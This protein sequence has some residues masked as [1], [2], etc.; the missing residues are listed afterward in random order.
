MPAYS[1]LSLLDLLHFS[2]NN[3]MFLAVLL[4]PFDTGMIW[5]NSNF[6]L[7][8]DLA[9]CRLSL[10]HTSSLTR[11]GILSFLY[12]DSPPCFLVDV[13][14]CCSVSQVSKPN[15]IPCVKSMYH[16][17]NAEKSQPAIFLILPL[18]HN[19]DCW[20]K[21]KRPIYIHGYFIY[22][23][24]GENEE[25]M[26]YISKFEK[27]I[28]V[29]SIT[30]QKLRIEQFPPLKEIV[31]NTPGYHIS[32]KCILYSDTYSKKDLKKIRRKIKYFFY[33]PFSFWAMLKKCY[34]VRFLL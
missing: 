8:P 10:L 18:Y 7:L 31:E 3:S 25:E 12:P 32:N 33:T 17:L 16:I 11:E 21:Y 2:H 20:G 24:I 19:T 30:F 29:D 1:I 5:S 26:L 9:H 27:E 4:P 14:N 34:V 22:G 13:P 23:N 28:G 15:A 6:L